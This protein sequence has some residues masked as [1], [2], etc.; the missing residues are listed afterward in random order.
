MVDKH[1]T[2]PA[3]LR[4]FVEALVDEVLELGRPLGRDARW[5]VLH[6]IEEYT[7]VVLGDVGRLTLCQL[8]SK[9]SERPNIDLVVVLGSTLDQFRG[10]PADGA[11]FRGAAL[12]LL[13]QDDCVAEI[14]QLN[15]T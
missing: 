6:N 14:G 11:D 15:L 12:L 1:V 7:C 3:T 5:L 4:I 2:G 8:N 9:D 10:H 13:S